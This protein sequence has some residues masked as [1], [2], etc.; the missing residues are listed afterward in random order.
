MEMRAYLRKRGYPFYKFLVNDVLFI[1]LNG[2]WYNAAG[3]KVADPR[4]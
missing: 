3:Q 1:F 2:E 4:K